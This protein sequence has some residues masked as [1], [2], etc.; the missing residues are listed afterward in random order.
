[1]LKAS[2]AQLQDYMDRRVAR[3]RGV[4]VIYNLSGTLLVGPGVWLKG[5]YWITAI[6]LGSATG[7]RRRRS[8][9]IEESK[10]PDVFTVHQITPLEQQDERPQKRGMRRAKRKNGLTPA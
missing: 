10:G 4:L 2:L 5:R 6:N 7:S 1:M 3:P 8:L 9:V